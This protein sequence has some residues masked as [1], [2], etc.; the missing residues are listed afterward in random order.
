M[1]YRMT[2]LGLN[3]RLER[4]LAYAFGWLSGIILFFVERNR[5]VRWH[6]AQSMITF[7][8]LSIV[9]FV[10]SILKMM[11][12]SIP[13]LGVLTSF[14]LGLLLSVLWWATIILWAWLLIMAGLQ[15]EDGQDYRLPF[16][17]EWVRRLV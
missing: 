14:G 16:V 11:L 10:V 5:S 1:M 3:I 4:M 9:M 12:G 13:L 8:T 15:S 17:S 2:S 7:G 6:A